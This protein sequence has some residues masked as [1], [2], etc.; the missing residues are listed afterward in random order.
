MDISGIAAFADTLAAARADAWARF[1]EGVTNRRS[2]FH[3]PMIASVSPEGRPRVRVVILRGC[4]PARGLLRFHT[5]RRSAKFAELSARAEA[6][7]TGYDAAAKIQVRVEGAVTLHVDDSV[8]DA[9][10]EGSRQFSR[11]CYGTHPGPGSELAEA[12]AFTLPSADDDIA[13]GRA[14]F[15]AVQ[16]H[17]ASLEWLYL[18]ASGH[19]RAHFDLA[20]EHPGRWLSP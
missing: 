13:A 8:A 18:A 10:W 5:D 14:N 19:R 7:M 1:C 12:G 15:C 9:A 20:S 4:E 2:P 16:L 6:A 11:I 17:V 3:S